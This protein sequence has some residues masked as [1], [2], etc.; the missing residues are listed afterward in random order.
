MPDDAS[1]RPSPAT[2][3]QSRIYGTRTGPVRRLAGFRK[4]HHVP[5]DHH[6]AANAFI[7][8]IGQSEVAA[9]AEALHGD[10]RR[11]FGLKR[12]ELHYAC[13]DGTAEI[14][15][16]AFGTRLVIDQ[17]PDTPGRYCLTTEVAELFDAE[18]R[19]DARFLECF[20]PR[21]DTVSFVFP[22]CVDLAPKIDA[23]EDHPDLADSLTYTPDASGFALDLSRAGLHIEVSQT[24]MTFTRTQPGGLDRLLRDSQL[25]F[26]WLT[27]IRP[28]QHLPAFWG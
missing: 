26:D 8:G 23:I 13:A 7:R 15:T 4:H 21:C 11:A 10:I 9:A 6:P 14:R 17:D 27:D 20:D 25:A 24:E 16:P 1:A 22:T 3:P 28:E 12:R 2:P 5:K 19:G 18:M